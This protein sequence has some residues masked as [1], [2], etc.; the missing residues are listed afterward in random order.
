MLVP[1]E[2]HIVGE[3]AYVEDKIKACISE[4][5]ICESG[6][7]GDRTLTLTSKAPQVRY[8]DGEV[9]DY[10]PGLELARE[11][12]DADNARL[13]AAGFDVLQFVPSAAENPDGPYFQALLASMSEHG[14]M[15]QFPLVHHQDDAVVDGRAR[16][17]AAKIL[18]LEVEYLRYGSERDRTAARRRDTPL[19]RVSVALHSNAGRLGSETWDAVHEQVARV[20][21]RDWSETAADLAV[22]E[23]W[24]RSVPADYSPQ[25]TVRRLPYRD[26]GEAKVQVTADNKVMLRSL[27]EAGGL[28]NYKIKMLDNYVP[29][30]RAR[31]EYSAGRKAVF[32]RAEDL[33]TGIAAM[34][35]ERRQRKLKIDPEWNQIR[36]WLQANFA[37][38]AL[39]SG[40]SG[41]TT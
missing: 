37:T 6:D 30:E 4:G 11:R 24:R 2:L 38:A 15:K 17:Q 10:P 40:G 25:F 34:Q 36:D 13:R 27:I 22:S 1:R 5:I 8:P 20:T 26:G 19:D 33:I 14:F 3:R 12:L 18:N 23:L 16:I 31:S 29:F 41:A 39:E 32:A 35:R 9:R 28:S 7:D 21:G